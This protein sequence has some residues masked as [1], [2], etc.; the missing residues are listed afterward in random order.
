[1][2][3]AKHVLRIAVPSPL[4]REFD[5]LPP[6]NAA[7]ASLQPGVRVR[8]P[9]GRRTTIGVLVDL[10]ADSDVDPKKLKAALEV[11]DREPVISGEIL[12]MVQWASAYYQY[13]L[14]EALAAALPVLLR[15]GQAAVADP[16]CAWRLTDAGR[17]VDLDTLARAPRQASVLTELQPAPAGTGAPATGCPGRRVTCPRRQGLD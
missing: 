13:P 2:A 7:L 4:Y 16:V 9:F 5:Y 1:M 11:L 6:A 12:D 14:G 8:V 3:T 15:E 17:R 10:P